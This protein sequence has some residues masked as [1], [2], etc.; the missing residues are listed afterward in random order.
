MDHSYI[1]KR[2]VIERYV[3][4][5]LST[6]ERVAFEEHYI[7]CEECLDRLEEAE[8]A[9]DVGV[10]TGAGNKRGR[11]WFRCRLIGVRPAVATLAPRESSRLRIVNPSA[12]VVPVFLLDADESAAGNQISAKGRFVVCLNFS[13]DPRATRFDAR[14]ADE[15]GRVISISDGVPPPP[16]GS[17][18]VTLHSSGFSTGRYV[19]SLE[20]RAA[21][22]EPVQTAQFAF[23]FLGA[24]ANA[25]RASSVQ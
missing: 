10:T 15:Y 18:G 9:V 13:P 20:G 4:D 6:A 5:R 24:D 12:F 1:E 23:T 19:I 7:A 22:D 16:S 17:V 2:E 14:V 8:G 25:D 11:D 3:T 21:D